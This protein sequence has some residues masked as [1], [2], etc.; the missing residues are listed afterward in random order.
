MI[1][2]YIMTMIIVNVAE[3]KA[4]LSQYLDALS[5]GERVIIA[6][7]NRPVA[8]LK[9][10]AAAR[11]EPRPIGGAK[12]AVQVLPSFFDPLPHDLLEGFEGR[13]P[14]TP[15]SRAAERRGP[16]YRPTASHRRRKEGR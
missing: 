9:A 16:G 2:T 14:S 4:K 5:R 11:T 15:A 6:K 7:W 10:L 1:Q 13:A 8:E 3:A 12:G